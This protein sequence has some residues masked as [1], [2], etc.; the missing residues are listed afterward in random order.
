MP[1]LDDMCGGD[2]QAL[3]SHLRCIGAFAVILGLLFGGL[4][5]LLQQGALALRLLKPPGRGVRHLLQRAEAAHDFG[6]LVLSLG[7]ELRHLVGARAR[8]R[9]ALLKL[10]NEE[11][12]G[13]RL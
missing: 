9:E 4:C 2:A 5:A 8:L 1:A 13:R 7:R 3:I 10:S 6:E 12:G 11:R